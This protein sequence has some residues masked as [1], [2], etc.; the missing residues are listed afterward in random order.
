MSELS[1]TLNL[2]VTADAKGITEIGEALTLL[3]KA[4][5]EVSGSTSEASA[6]AT[7]H[8]R[9]MEKTAQEHNNKM[10]EIAAKGSANSLKNMVT[11]Y[12]TSLGFT[13]AH[14]AALL[15]EAENSTLYLEAEQRKASQERRAAQVSGNLLQITE[16]HRMEQERRAARA[17]GNLLQITE[18][19][20][21][22]QER[23]AA[24]VSGNLLQITEEHR[25]EQERRAARAAGNLLQITEE[26]KM[27]QEHEAMLIKRAEMD[28][29][30]GQMELSR[31]IKLR[32]ELA[33][34][35]ANPT[36]G[37][38]YAEAK[39]APAAIADVRPIKEM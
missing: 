29:A 36:L 4:L 9:D 21:M 25:M 32:K 3:K 5:G 27:G 23:R 10:L 2:V 1:P 7:A 18:E 24:Q 14:V 22:A 33:A 26:Y 20:S 12:D 30:Y 31:Q 35:Q 39:F 15:R 16:E 37:A 19:H 28:V 8:S 6:A 34:V 11:E 17:A 13:K 38:A